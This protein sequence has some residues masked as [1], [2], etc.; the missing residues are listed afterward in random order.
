MRLLKFL[1]VALLVMPV[2]MGTAEA[3]DLYYESDSVLFSGNE[4]YYIDN[5]SVKSYDIKKK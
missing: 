1:I 5:S 4:V 3:K 2:F